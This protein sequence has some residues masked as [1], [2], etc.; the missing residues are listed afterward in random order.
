MKYN[1]RFHA[2]QYGGRAQPIEEN[3]SFLDTENSSPDSGTQDSS[4][5]KSSSFWY[6]RD[7]ELPEKTVPTKIH[8]ERR[9]PAK[10]IPVTIRKKRTIER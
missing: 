2:P 7:L 4:Q 6:P 3:T 5:E 9:D 1:G 10:N 8:P